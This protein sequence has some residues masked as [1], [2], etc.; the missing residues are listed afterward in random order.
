MTIHL[1]N[2]IRTTIHDHGTVMVAAN[3]L[4]NLDDALHALSMSE[5]HDIADLLTFLGHDD[6]ARKVLRGVWEGEEEDERDPMPWVH[7]WLGYRAN[8]EAESLIFAPRRNW[9]EEESG[10][11]PFF[12]TLHTHMHASESIDTSTPSTEEN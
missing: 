6:A 2:V 4:A 3:T 10:R 1:G 8:E 11:D 5:G 9:G 7:L 12:N